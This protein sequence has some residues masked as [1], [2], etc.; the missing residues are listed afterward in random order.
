MDPDLTQHSLRNLANKRFI[1]LAYTKF[2][3]KDT[4]LFAPAT[5]IL[6]AATN[7]Q[8]VIANRLPAVEAA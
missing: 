5:P 4:Y 2:T 6:E 3:G 1:L 8:R 7:A